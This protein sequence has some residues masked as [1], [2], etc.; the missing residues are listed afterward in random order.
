MENR[1]AVGAHNANPYIFARPR[2]SLKQVR[3]WDCLTAV[4]KQANLQEPPAETSTK[5]RKYVATVS[6]IIDL[7]SNALDWLAR[8][9]CHDITV[10]RDFYRQHESTLELAKVSKLLLAVDKGKIAKLS[11]RKLDDIDLEGVLADES[12]SEEEDA[13]VCKDPS[14]GGRKLGAQQ[15]V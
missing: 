12:S 14:S 11:G 3:G 15:C 6:Q 9:L 10:H 5:L 8:H 1:E 2:N 13:D 7:N 4:A